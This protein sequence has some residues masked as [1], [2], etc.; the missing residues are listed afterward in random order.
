MEMESLAS[1]IEWAA[2]NIAFNLDFIPEDKLSYKP[3][4]T[5]NSALEVIGHAA[6]AIGFFEK[7]LKGEPPGNPGSI[8]T[9]VPAT[10]E[11]AKAMIITSATNYSAALRSLSPEDAGNIVDLQFAK[12]PLGFVASMAVTDLIHHH[13]QIA[14]IQTIL[15]DTESHFD[16]SLLP[17]F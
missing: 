3:S 13:G 7:T 9:P 10:L 11:E 16:M 2:K 14:Y 17:Q 8:E 15:G 6:V 12:L 4:P 5:A 1:Q